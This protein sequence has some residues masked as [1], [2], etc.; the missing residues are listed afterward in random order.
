M[1][2]TKATKRALLMS[3]LSM[4]ICIAMLVGSTFAWFTDSVTSG[5]NVIKAGNLDISATYQ[6]VDMTDGTEQYTI[7]DFDRVAGGVIKFSES[8]TDINEDNSIISEELWEPGAVGAKLLTV[9][10]DGSLA[11]K[12]RLSFTVED[13]GLQDALWFDFI[14]VNEGA[15]VGTFTKR[16]M[17]TLNSFASSLELPLMPKETAG[18]S[19]SFI[20][21]YGMYEEAGNQ[22]MNTSFEADVSVLAVQMPYEEDSFDKNYDEKAAYVYT[23]A[24]PGELGKIAEKA[25]SGD[26]IKLSGSEK[27][28]AAEVNKVLDGVILQGEADADG[29]PLT[30]VE[31]DNAPVD[32]KNNNISYIKFVRAEGATSGEDLLDIGDSSGKTSV[33]VE[34]CIFDYSSEPGISYPGLALRG[35]GTVKGCQF[36]GNKAIGID[37]AIGEI[38]IEDCTYDNTGFSS[39]NNKM[40]IDC[41]S[42]DP[43]SHITIKGCEFVTSGQCIDMYCPE[44]TMEGCTLNG[45][46]ITIRQKDSTWTTHDNEFK[47]NFDMMFEF[48][49]D[50]ITF[51]STNDKFSSRLSS[52]S[53][54]GYYLFQVDKSRTGIRITIDGK[55]P[56]TDWVGPG[57]IETD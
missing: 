45:T 34:N 47:G 54:S 27:Y 23:A 56:K 53:S 16:A 18:D 31:I 37:R 33:S 21:I 48:M 11:A 5:Q 19:V 2:K 50:N 36:K 12:I 43:D 46:S 55:A 22:Y 57:T 29:N 6:N 40:A 35:P 13:G 51:N 32:L 28:D 15:V 4:L 1:N 42:C 17:S 25:K 8:K 39:M 41:G 10:N 38:L 7:P 14:R 24:N 20:L 30:V 26:I 9:R 49:A 3:M 44:V 52:G